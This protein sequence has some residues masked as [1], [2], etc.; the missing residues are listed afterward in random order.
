MFYSYSYKHYRSQIHL[1]SLCETTILF[2]FCAS[3][4]L[5]T[6][7]IDRGLQKDFLGTQFCPSD[8]WFQGISARYFLFGFYVLFFCFFKR[9][10]SV[11]ALPS[12]T[13]TTPKL[14]LIV[15]GKLVVKLHMQNCFLKMKMYEQIARI[16]TSKSPLMDGCGKDGINE[17]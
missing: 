10:V 2:I 5:E 1:T 9:K 12:T 4:N 7:K 13:N 17:F 14:L 3:K 11:V 16:H 6:L 15:S 8:N